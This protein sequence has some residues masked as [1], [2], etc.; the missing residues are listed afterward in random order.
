MIDALFM[1]NLR[2]FIL[3]KRCLLFDNELMQSTE[4]RMNFILKEV[5]FFI[6]IYSFH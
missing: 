1:F 2:P 6:I 5:F 4:V 3:F